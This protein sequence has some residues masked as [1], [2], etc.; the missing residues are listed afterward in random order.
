MQ[1]KAQVTLFI[2]IAVVVLAA[3][4]FSFIYI[5]RT[6]VAIPTKIQP[7][8]DYLVECIS[9]HVKDTS[10]IAGMQA[11]YLDLPEF[12]SGSEYMPF[13]S[14]LNFIGMEVPYWFYVSG[15]NLAREQRPE[16]REIE[17][18]FSDYLEEKIQECDLSNF[19]NNNYDIELEGSPVIDVDIKKNSI[20][21][22]VKWP[23]NIEFEDAKAR[24][25]DHKVITRSNFGQLYDTANTIYESEKKDL[26]L[27]NYAIDVLRL[28]APVTGIELSCAPKTWLISELRKE[29]NEALEGNIGAIKVSGSY[30]SFSNAEHSY[31]EVDVGRRIDEQVYFLYSRK[32]PH[33]FEVWPSEN[34]IMR[35]D[36]MGNQPGFGILSAVG[37]CYVPY[38]FIYDLKFPVL[39]Q[40][41]KEEDVFQ[42]PVLVIIDKNTVKEAPDVESEEV[43]FDI[44]QH[45][46]QQAT[47]F[48]YS[49]QTYP[50]EA[51]IGY[52]C[53]NQICDVGRTTISEGK[54]SL[55]TFLPQCYNGFLIAKAP[56]YVN[57]KIQVS[58][59][60]AFVANIFLNPVHTLNLDLNLGSDEYA[61]INFVSEDYS[62][63]I[64]YPE[65]KQIE[66][67]EGDYEVSV[68]LFKESSISLESQQVEKCIKVPA[69]GIAGIFG[70]MQEQCFDIEVPEQT[71]TNVLFGGG[72]TE[73]SVTESELL[74]A[75]RI[76]IETS[77][78]DIPTNIFELG[79]IYGLI[80]ISELQIMLLS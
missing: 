72:K 20:D 55:K 75:S 74:S 43:I 79:D 42:F 13:S 45:R 57:T 78:F 40:I 3:A 46:T 51:D 26:F 6:R 70:A 47:I 21:I 39:I 14:R 1:K 56:G 23:L 11:G 61:I 27:D 22:N 34:G 5:R 30:Y 58:S 17:Q 59:T 8:E 60:G 71:L 80:D 52:K 38:H 63:S 18:Q 44:C 10:K 9:G 25:I 31:F 37:F 73:F 68:S 16:L 28:Y 4:L 48:T 33:V 36:P 76:R 65:Q 62:T 64:Y 7:V 69:G 53:F 19:L 54:A 15:N 32:M 50:L 66:L 77:S 49:E 29:I 35:A 41:I 12:E 67:S 2:I 24:I